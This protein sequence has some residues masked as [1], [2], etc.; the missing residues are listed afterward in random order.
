MPFL[1]LAVGEIVR[2]APEN[3]VYLLVEIAFRFEHRTP[4]QRIETPPND[5]R[6]LLEVEVCSLDSEL[7]DQ[8]LAKPGLNLVMS[9][10]TRQILEERY[11]LCA[12]FGHKPHV[13]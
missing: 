8:Q 2:H 3:V 11:G 6:A 5:R 12:K 7:R 13:A 4:D 1:A 9:G 10:L